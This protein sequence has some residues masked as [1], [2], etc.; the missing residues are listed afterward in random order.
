VDYINKDKDKID[1]LLTYDEIIK[2]YKPRA[3]IGELNQD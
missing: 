2:K 1:Y 3:D